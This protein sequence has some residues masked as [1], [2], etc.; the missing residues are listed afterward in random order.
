MSQPGCPSATKHARP[1]LDSPAAGRSATDGT[2]S[3]EQSSANSRP[4]KE[5]KPL[6]GEK[7]QRGPAEDPLVRI[8]DAGFTPEQMN[9]LMKAIQDQVKTT[10][11][12]QRAVTQSLPAMHPLGMMN[13]AIMPHLPTSSPYHPSA[14]HLGTLLQAALPVGGHAW[15]LQP[16]GH[17]LP[18]QQAVI[19]PAAA[20]T[21][22]SSNNTAM[23]ADP[24]EVKKRQKKEI[25]DLKVLYSAA[26]TIS[27]FGS[28]IIAKD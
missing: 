10:L 8:P 1:V 28:K 23:H 12:A 2:G 3:G 14:M 18:H 13:P 22:N 6:A 19:R 15:N 25:S 7:R 9:V 20:Q 5:D 24:C 4:S 27:C 11:E 26:A 21:S 16:K 17:I